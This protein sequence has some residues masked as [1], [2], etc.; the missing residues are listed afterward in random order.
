MRRRKI[1]VKKAVASSTTTNYILGLQ[2][3]Q[4][5]CYKEQYQNRKSMLQEIHQKSVKNIR[6]IF[7]LL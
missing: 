3:E 6:I 2:R 7:S 4:R 1:S 5:F